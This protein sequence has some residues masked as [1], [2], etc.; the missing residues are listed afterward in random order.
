MDVLRT[1]LAAV[2][3]A[4]AFAAVALPACGDDDGKG[5]A[6]EIDK[7]VKKGAKEAEK[8]GNEIDDD[9]KGRDEKRQRDK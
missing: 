1:R 5:G 9:V 7:G 2:V 4:L 8:Q 3:A 6:E